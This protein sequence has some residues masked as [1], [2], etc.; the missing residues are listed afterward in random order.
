MLARIYAYLCIPRRLRFIFRWL[1]TFLFI[2]VLL[3]VLIL[4]ARILLAVRNNHAHL[5]SYPLPHQP[6]SP[7]FIVYHPHQQRHLEEDQ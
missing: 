7:D 1:A 2:I 4:F 6:L 3:L 5:L